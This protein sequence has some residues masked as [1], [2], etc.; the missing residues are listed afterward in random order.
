MESSFSRRIPVANLNKNLQ[1]KVE[2]IAA[3]NSIK[4]NG[5]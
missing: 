3:P 4:T 1:I 2:T 5:G